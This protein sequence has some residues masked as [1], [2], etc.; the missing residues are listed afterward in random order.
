MYVHIWT[1]RACV[2]GARRCI[3]TC[4]GVEREESWCPPP[5]TPSLVLSD[6]SHIESGDRCFLPLSSSGPLFA[7]LPPTS[8]V[9][10]LQAHVPTSSLSCMM[11]IWAQVLIL[12]SMPSYTQSHL[13]SLI[14]WFLIRSQNS[15]CLRSWLCGREVE[16]L[17]HRGW[18]KLLET[19]YLYISI[20]N[21]ST[22]TVM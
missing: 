5:M 3:Y 9:L 17:F 4:S 8:W 15:P 12:C 18:L 1:L 19:T 21:S 14:L 2:L 10:G 22:I 16:W 7:V 20:H 11:E 6:S 13:S